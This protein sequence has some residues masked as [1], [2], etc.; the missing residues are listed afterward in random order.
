MLTCTPRIRPNL[1]ASTLLFERRL[2]GSAHRLLTR[3]HLALNACCRRRVAFESQGS[4]ET[5]NSGCRQHFHVCRSTGIEASQKLN[6]IGTSKFESPRILRAGKQGRRSSH[7]RYADAAIDY[8]PM[9]H[10]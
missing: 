10:I 3:S 8:R 7:T 6:A 9:F 5:Q 2:E 4:M 1:S